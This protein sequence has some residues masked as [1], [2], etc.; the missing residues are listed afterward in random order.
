MTDLRSRMVEAHGGEARWRRLSGLAAAVSLGGTEFLSHLQPQPLVNVDAAIDLRACRITLSPFPVEGQVGVFEATR[1]CILTEEGELLESRPAPGTVTRSMRH[2]LVWDTLDVLFVAGVTLMQCMLFP[3]LLARSG[4]DE[5][6]LEDAD[7]PSAML[8]FAADLPLVAHE[9][10]YV[11]DATGMVQ[12]IDYAP[13]AY[14]GWMRVS[15]LMDGF[16]SFD[17]L[18][19]PTRQSLHPL[20]PG[21]RLW[22]A[23]RLAWIDLDD[24]AAR[25]DVQSG[26]AEARAPDE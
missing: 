1:V 7:R 20:L 25:Y 21:G 17:G 2:W 5:Q 26:P 6:A 18:L 24:L 14:G 16:E 8:R 12:R 22:R 15:Q 9:Q 13:V 4:T 3:W 10:V 19:L 23:T 11:A